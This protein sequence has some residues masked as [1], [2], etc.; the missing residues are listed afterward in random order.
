MLTKNSKAVNRSTRPALSRKDL[1][2]DQLGDLYLRPGF[3]LRRA[4]QIAV[5]IFEEECAAIG[6]TPPQHGVLITIERHPGIDQAGL[7]RA[8]GFDRATIGQVTRGLAVRGLLRRASSKEDRRRKTLTVTPRG[9]SVLKRAQHAM[10]STSD[11]LLAPLPHADRRIFMDL[12]IRL[13]SEL[14]PHSRTPVRPPVG[15]QRNSVG[16][17]ISGARRNKDKRSVIT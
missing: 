4:H 5:G 11:R 13:T 16:R 8:L 2:G 1:R 15:R 7:A 6:L 9:V 17:T 3:L 12:L 14:N 10:H